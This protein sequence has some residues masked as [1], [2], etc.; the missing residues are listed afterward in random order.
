[1][2]ESKN[3][4][5]SGFNNLNSV[6]IPLSNELFNLPH[7]P[8]DI[9]GTRYELKNE[10][11][12]TLMGKDLGSQLL[13]REEQSGFMENKLKNIFNSIDWTFHFTEQIFF[14]EKEKNGIEKTIIQMLDLSGMEKFYH[15]LKKESLIDQDVKTPPPHVT[16]F[17][18]NCDHGI[19]VKSTQDLEKL[20]VQSMDMESLNKLL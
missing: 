13:S 6:I 17:T 20:T 3:L 7:E 10:F 8:V 9:L 11:H 14:L 19:G 15:H 5:W 2:C 16:L 1:M 12:I 18:N 4:T